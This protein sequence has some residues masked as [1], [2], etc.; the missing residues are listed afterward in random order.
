MQTNETG[1]GNETVGDREVETESDQGHVVADQDQENVVV[2]PDP[3]IG[4][5]GKFL[6]ILCLLKFR[7]YACYNNELPNRD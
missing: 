3:E 2:D 6:Q 5:G 4:K 7:K 1:V